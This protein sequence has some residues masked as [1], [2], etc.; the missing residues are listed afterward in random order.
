MPIR[1]GAHIAMVAGLLFIATRPILGQDGPNCFL[2]DFEPK[3]AI[4][5]PYVE[6]QKNSETATVTVTI[7][8]TDT[9]GKVSKTILG[10]AVAVWVSRSVNNPILIGH[11]RK[12]AP[13][14]IRFP[15]GSWS[16]IYFWGKNPGDLPATIPDGANN[17][18]PVGLYPK[19][20][21][22]QALTVDGYYDMRDQLETQGLITINYGYARYGLS[23]KPAEQAAHYAA[24]WV[25][26]DDG[27][28]KFWEIG[29]EVAGP[30]EAGWQ[31]D[32]TQNGDKQPQI[33]TG[34]LY[35][36]HFK[37][38]ADSMKAAAAKWG[39]TIYIGGIILHY[40]GSNSWNV[41]DRKWNEGFFKEAGDAADFYVIHNYFGNTATIKS[42]IDLARSTIN[43]NITFIRQDIANKKASL[44][45]VALTEWNCSGPDLAKTSI[46]NGM[47]AVVLFCEMI[48]NNFGMSAR[49][50]IANWE[51]DG[52][53]YFGNNSSIPL[54]NPRPDFYYIYYLRR[55]I[56]DHMVGS[57]VPASSDIL[58]YVTTYHSGHMG[59]VLVNKGTTGKVV[60]FDMGTHGVGERYYVYSLT[61]MD[62]SQW[63]QSVNVNGAGPTGSA[64]GPL[65][66]LADIPAWAYPVENS[67]T[68]SSPANSVQYILIEPGN[69]IVSGISENQSGTV[70]GFTLRQN[71]PNPFN[72]LTTISYALQQASVATL[73]VY[74]VYGRET[75]VLVH[76]EK[77]AAGEHEVEFEA[78]GL[79]TGVYFYLLY[80]QNRVETKKMLLLK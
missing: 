21:P 39:E 18:K 71:H 63:P 46:A 10:N 8:A 73:K 28:T 31:I 78:G 11:L 33:I 7:N 20:G 61:G 9:I 59:I 64:W 43:Q 62:N 67:I 76:N 52:M 24:D 57:S 44:K 6:A 41:A 2:E 53:F 22:Y 36:K 42:Q 49:W 3:N 68:L 5:P 37:I 38:F 75:A 23:G 26:H 60:Q 30:W 58:A 27:R 66:G 4:I 70:R 80:A 15:G 77:K 54:W 51:S 40:D 1:Q 65:D 35:G 55:F 72:P 50:L 48:K 16:D 32:T 79:P 12:L 25:R 47:Q 74:D 29:N 13:G 34:E 14:L 45:P 69:H 17:G 19:F 56:G